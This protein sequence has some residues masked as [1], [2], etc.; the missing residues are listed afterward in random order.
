MVGSLVALLLVL[1]VPGY[2]LVAALFPGNREIG[3]IERVALSAG[4]SLALV[5]LVGLVLN[6]TPFGIQLP[7][8]LAAIALLSVL[9]G[10]GAYWRRI[11][12]PPAER[13]GLSI[14]LDLP[15]WTEG[16]VVDKALTIGVVASV[17]IAGGAFA[18]VV[19]VPR[20]GQ[21][22]TEFYLLGPGGT[23]A[24]WPTHL[25]V[26][27]PASVFIGIINREAAS[28]AY[29]V[30][31]DL[32]GVQFAYD[33]NGTYNHTIVLNGTTWSWLNTT[34]SDGQSWTH[35]YGFSIGN[36]GFW[37]IQFL[38]Y[39]RGNLYAAY[40]ELHLYIHVP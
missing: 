32:L 13:L 8:L 6:F 40:K 14:D 34:L 27:E 29:T 15:G 23:A 19:L 10:L 37:E 17:A 31:V 12:L 26:S 35:P 24:G 11:Q 16:A 25:N 22:F 1:F 9:I 30:R 5:P 21:Q 39:T 2:V 33:A 20:V 28:V 36:P 38:L 18:Y 7:S 4:L 3:W